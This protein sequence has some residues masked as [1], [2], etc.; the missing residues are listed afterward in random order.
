MGRLPHCDMFVPG[1]K[2]ILQIKYEPRA[3]LEFYLISGA[4]SGRVHGAELIRTQTVFH[5]S[6]F[7]SSNL[8]KGHNGNKDY[9]GHVWQTIL[10]WLLVTF[11]SEVGG[12]FVFTLRQKVMYTSVSGGRFCVCANL[13]GHVYIN[14][15]WWAC[16]W[17]TH[18]PMFE[19]LAPRACVCLKVPKSMW[20]RVC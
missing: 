1:S 3:C 6:L 16:W 17:V 11:W 18:R 9:S 8:S 2:Y 20:A 14:V 12:V 10:A 19:C 7:F 5:V 4:Q 15:R 13:K